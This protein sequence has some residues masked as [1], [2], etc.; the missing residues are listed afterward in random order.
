MKQTGILMRPEMVRATKR[1]DK[2]ETRRIIKPQPSKQWAVEIYCKCGPGSV[3]ASDLTA[4]DM[5]IDSLL[6]KC[7]YGKVGDILYVKETFTIMEPEHCSGYKERFAYRAD[8]TS[9]DGEEIRQDY[10]KCGYPYQ[11]KSAVHMKPEY[12]RYG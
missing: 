8:C 3:N 4:A 9:K 5:E 1:G 6:D 11:W 2:T 12:A 7:P 10:I